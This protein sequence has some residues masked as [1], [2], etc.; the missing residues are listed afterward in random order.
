LLLR[1]TMNKRVLIPI[2]NGSC[3]MQIS[4]FVACFARCGTKVVTA[5][6]DGD[7]ERMVKTQHIKVRASAN[8]HVFKS[9]SA[10]TRL[11][12]LIRCKQI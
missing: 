6:I 10:R 1:M 12:P 2:A 11:I 4:S 3:E 8:S 7:H 5:C 9:C